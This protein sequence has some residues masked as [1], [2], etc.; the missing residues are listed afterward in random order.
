M[1]YDTRPRVTLLQWRASTR[2]VALLA[3][4]FLVQTTSGCISNEYRIKKTELQRLAELP[5][6]ARGASVR[7]GQKLGSRRGDAVEAPAVF[8]PTNV[9]Q[10]DAYL[11]GDSP[12]FPVV[13]L[14]IAGGGGGSP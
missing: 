11:G 4:A 12:D 13:R 3:A 10:P 14:E 5:P 1:A 6:D 8:Q 7:V 9:Y 2:G